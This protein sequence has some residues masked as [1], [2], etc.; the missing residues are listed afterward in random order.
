VTEAGDLFDLPLG[1]D[2]EAVLSEIT[3]L[4]GNPT[5]DLDWKCPYFLP[6][7]NMRLLRW[8]SLIAVVRT[9]D[10]GTGDLGLAGWRYKLDG[11]GQP[12]A[13]GPK[14]EHVELPFGLELGDPIGDAT[15]V[16]GGAVT[17]PGHGLWMVVEFDSFS[18]EASGLSADPNAPIDGVQQGVGFDCE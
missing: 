6:D 2:A 10:T 1:S 15:A 17:V 3:D 12:E 7:P 16:G 4:Y 14:P 9:V 13:G 8:G 11:S 5:S 18:V